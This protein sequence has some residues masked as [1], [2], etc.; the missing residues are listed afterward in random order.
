MTINRVIKKL[1]K[2]DN[3]KGCFGS[4]W[5]LFGVPIVK[6]EF[7]KDGKLYRDYVATDGRCLLL[8]RERIK[9]IT[10]ENP[11][12]MKP[13]KCKFTTDE[14]KLNTIPI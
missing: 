1:E 6:M 13:E 7:E 14:K 9:E 11:I 12:I 4:F 2:M 3:K 10:I 8:D 5:K